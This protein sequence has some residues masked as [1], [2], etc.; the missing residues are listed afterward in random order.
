MAQRQPV[1]KGMA[2][3]AAVHGRKGEVDVG[4]DAGYSWRAERG[5]A[6]PLGPATACATDK[7]YRPAP[8][9]DRPGAEKRLD[10]GGR[11]RRAEGQDAVLAAR[12]LPGPEDDRRGPVAAAQPAERGLR[13]D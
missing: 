6:R 13:R 10:P 9:A 1:Q 2:G 12:S 5:M 4:L 11:S 7:A 3:G 8:R